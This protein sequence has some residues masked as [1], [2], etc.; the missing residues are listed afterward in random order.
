MCEVTLVRAGGRA[1]ATK[2]HLVTLVRAGGRAAATKC[3]L[4][5]HNAWCLK[6]M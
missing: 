2:C 3:H 6:Q 5:E 1:A 4:V